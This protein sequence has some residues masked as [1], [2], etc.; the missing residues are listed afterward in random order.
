M[1]AGS[2]YSTPRDLFALQRAL[3]RGDLGERAKSLLLR[4][5]GLAWNGVTHGF[6]AFA[7]H[8]ES[9]GVTVIFAAN[10]HS[11][12]LDRIRRDVPKIAG[13][14]EVAPR[15]IDATTVEVDAEVLKRYEGNYELRPGR[16]LPLRIVD[17]QV[18]VDEWLV[19]PTSETKFFSPQ[20]YGRIKVVL[21]GEGQVERLDWTIGDQT[22]PMPRTGPLDGK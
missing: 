12:A 7:D 11:G 17:G 5:T 16:T 14:E 1:G 22:Y 19:I 2:V 10:L 21:D 3:V 4:P 9:T 13:G 18:R 8:D 15:P 6:R 20:D